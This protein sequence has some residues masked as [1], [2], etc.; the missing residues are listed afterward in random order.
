M[1]AR[2]LS[3]EISVLL[4]LLDIP[5]NPVGF[6]V[7]SLWIELPIGSGRFA[8][9]IHREV[10]QVGRARVLNIKESLFPL[11]ARF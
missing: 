7:A 1:C 2:Y 11:P 8:E 4:E 3:V 6:V 9:N 10:D 5:D